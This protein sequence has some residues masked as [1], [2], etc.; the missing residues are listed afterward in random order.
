MLVLFFTQHLFQSNWS[1]VFDI[2]QLLSQKWSQKVSKASFCSKTVGT[3]FVF[4]AF[5]STSFPIILIVIVWCQSIIFSEMEPETLKSELLFEDSGHSICCFRSSLNI[6][7]NQFG[8]YCLMLNNYFLRNEARNSQKQTFAR[9]QWAQHLLFLFFTQHLFKSICSLLFDVNQL[10]SQKW[11]P[12]L[13][14]ANFC[15]KT[16]GTAFAVFCSSSNIFPNQF[17]YYCLFSINFFSEIESETLKSELLFEDSGHSICCF[18][19]SLNIFSNQFGH[20]CLMLNNY[21][22]RNGARNS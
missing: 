14:K 9:R 13:S 19:S 11:S 7:S 21:F 8:H 20:Y 6:F 17:D 4:F 18:R 3:I 2:N 16:V 22:L 5:H 15:S 12:E 1:L 10:F